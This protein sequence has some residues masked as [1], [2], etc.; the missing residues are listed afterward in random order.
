VVPKNGYNNVQLTYAAGDL[1]RVCDF[2]DFFETIVDFVFVSPHNYSFS[3]EVYSTSIGSII[4]CGSHHNAFR[5]D[6]VAR[7]EWNKI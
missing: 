1:Q 3:R 7:Y 4:L 5:K 6:T 2:C